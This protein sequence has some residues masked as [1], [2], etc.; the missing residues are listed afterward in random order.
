MT[1][2]SHN[3]GESQNNGAGKRKK[4]TSA[5]RKLRRKLAKTKL[6]A[7][8]LWYRHRGLSPS[9]VF[10]GSYP[11]SGSTWSRFTLFEIMTGQESGFVA[12]NAAMHGVGGHKTGMAALPG[13]GR[14]INTHEKYRNE[15]KKA[16][17]VVR[18]VR[19]VALSEF[20]YTTAIEFFH[21]DMD[22]FLTTFLCKKISPFGPWQSQVGSWLDSPI[23]GTPNMLLLR[24]EDLR[25]D[26]LEAFTRMVDFLGV[27]ADTSRI[28]RAIANNSL[29]KM[30][31]KEEREPVRASV[32]DRFVRNGL[33]QGWR[34]KLSMSQVQF[35]EQYT[36]SILRRLGYPLVS[37][38][39]TTAEVGI[40]PEL[41]S[42]S[43]SSR[44][45]R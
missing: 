34:S 30:K 44:L 14:M 10:F 41:Q 27:K 1:E 39:T 20:A 5:Y 21:G 23:A 29:N 45:G 24:Y 31:E 7:P 15:Y 16:I 18:D 38:E 40:S 26:P 19:D 11:R 36:G 35:I 42:V 28:Q 6:R 13:N 4:P 2:H 33:V 37:D 9:D 32:K 3:H 25:K 43:A 12:V 22:K 8:L 17:Y